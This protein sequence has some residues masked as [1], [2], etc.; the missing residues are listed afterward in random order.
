MTKASTPEK[1]KCSDCLHYRQTAHPNKVGLCVSSVKAHDPAPRCFTPDYTKAL[2][3]T[4]ELRQLVA[5]VNNK[6]P[7][8]LRILR[9]ILL[10]GKK[11]IGQRFY[12]ALGEDYLSNYVKA[13]FVGKTSSG[14]L[15][16]ASTPPGVETRVFFS[17]LLDSSNLLTPA[18]F[19]KKRTALM[20]DGRAVDPS[21]KLSKKLRLEIEDDAYE[22]PTIDNAPK[23]QKKK[24][25]KQKEFLEFSW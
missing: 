7:Q 8:Q 11:N 23:E 15:V 24:V 3:S 9:A 18:Q 10:L 17:Y 4:E 1:L 25:K 22:I 20:R 19:K 21:A 16:F 14:D 5:L 13:Y 2:A 12:F 6:T